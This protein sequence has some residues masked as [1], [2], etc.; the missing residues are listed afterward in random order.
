MKREQCLAGVL[1][2]LLTGCSASGPAPSPAAESH[3]P[4][5]TD[6]SALTPYETPKEH[7]TRRYAEFTD[8]VIPA[9]D[10]GPLIPF[11]GAT[12]GRSQNGW[13]DSFPLWGLVT[14]E[15]EVVVD[16]VF[17]SAFAP[18]GYQSN[19]QAA[20]LP[21]VL[22]LTK[23]V[24][25]PGGEPRALSALCARDGHWC[26][27]F[28][29]SYDW[30]FFFDLDL[31][32]GIPLW[33]GD[34]QMVFLDPADGHEL[35]AADARPYLEMGMEYPWQLLS[36]L[37]V[38]ERYAPFE[39]TAE[40]GTPRFGIADLDAGT[41]ILLDSDILS[42]SPFSQGLCQAQ[43]A[44]GSGYLDGNGQW[45]IDPIYGQAG[46]FFRGAAS[47]RNWEGHFL[48]LSPDGS[49]LLQAPEW[50]TEV[51]LFPGSFP[52]WRCQG[53]SQSL[54]LDADLT[55]IELPKDTQRSQVLNDGWIACMRSDGGWTLF[56]QGETCLFSSELGQPQTVQDG[57]ALLQVPDGGAWSLVCLKTG[58]SVSLPHSNFADFQR[59]AITGQSYIQ[60]G[61]EELQQ[62]TL[63]R[64]DGETI[65]TCPYGAS[66]RDSLEG[67][68]ILREREDFSTLLTQE[69]ETVFCWNIPTPWD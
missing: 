10:Y 60:T 56:R 26:T 19:G 65:S 61:S 57:Y 38:E 11:H 13:T 48:F 66:D 68:L 39:I 42:L 58:D 32:K 59:D 31:S 23:T 1:A 69:S 63:F 43:T 35:R 17:S 15:G 47:V 27:E 34:T 4:V 62:W 24:E 67:G 3:S 20:G 29:Y 8:T 64:L 37:R 33:K 9:D 50:C 6:W 45:V 12:L 21:D 2:L 14:L 41:H 55:P 54:Y 25:V 44:S 16:P 28:L 5:Y 53:D 49:V 7:Y 18:I 30:E 46:D 51:D 36:N 22:I 40:D 52:L